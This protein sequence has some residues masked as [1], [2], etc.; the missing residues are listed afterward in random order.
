MKR[1]KINSTWEEDEEERRIF[2]SSLSY[3]DRLKYFFKLRRKYNFNR[4]SY[5]P[6]KIFKIHSVSNGI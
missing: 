1:F 5:S 4:E 6:V 3:S 2:F